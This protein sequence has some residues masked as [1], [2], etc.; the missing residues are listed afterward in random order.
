MAPMSI[1]SQ[2]LYTLV[3]LVAL[4]VAGLGLASDSGAEPS[5]PGADPVL[6]SWPDWPYQSSC[7]GPEEAFDPLVVFAGPTGA[8][9]GS[10]PAEKALRREIKEQRSWAEPLLAPRGWRLVE[11]T[12]TRAQ[13]SRGRLTGMLE[14]VG[15]EKDK[16][17]TWRFAGYSEDC[18][19]RTVL[20]ENRTVITWSLSQKQKRLTPQSRTLW[21][22]LGPGE[23]AS[24]TAQNP[25]AHFR[26]RTL[27][28]KLLMIAWLKPVH[29][30]QTCEGTIEPSRKVRLPAPLG[31]LRLYDGSVFPPVPAGKTRIR[32]Y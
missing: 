16:D 11:E 14:W 2:V 20:G 5:P 8:E 18:D 26:F 23:C 19:P 15:F 7:G 27:G 13:F 4:G 22:D 1:R 9:T 30:N 32:Y 17:G 31:E 25:R 12:E 10:S 3:V 24:G 6:A 29:G 28:D 21:I